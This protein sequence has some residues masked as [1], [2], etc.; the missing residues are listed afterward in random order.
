MLPLYSSPHPKAL[1][2]Y[3]THRYLHVRSVCS[4][5]LTLLASTEKHVIN[6]I[7]IGFTREVYVISAT[8]GNRRRKLITH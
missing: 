7:D 8:I 2:S 1:A 3:Y 4:T 6:L 5:G